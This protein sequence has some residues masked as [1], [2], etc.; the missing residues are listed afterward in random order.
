M[1]LK[2]VI[3]VVSGWLLVMLISTKCRKEQDKQRYKVNKD[4]I[5]EQKKQYYGNNKDK[6]VKL[7]KQYREENEDKIAE[8]KNNIMRLTKMRY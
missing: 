7:R 4:K 8:Q 3:V 1:F 5:L 6:I 2:D